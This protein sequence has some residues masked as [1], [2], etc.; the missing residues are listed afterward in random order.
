MASLSFY[1]PL[2]STAYIANSSLGP[3][4]G[5]Y[6]APAAASPPTEDGSYNYCFMPHPNKALYTLPPPVAGQSI[7]ADLVYLEYLQRHQRRSPYNILP[8]GEVSEPVHCCQMHISKQTRT[9]N[10]TATLSIPIFTQLRRPTLHTR[11]LCT[12]GPIQIPPT[13]LSTP[14]STVHASIPSS[15]SAGS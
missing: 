15:Q 9:R 5:I 3:Y 8:A 13:H 12:P 4:A 11:S 1:P 14:T 2:N 10:T 6:S 7:Q